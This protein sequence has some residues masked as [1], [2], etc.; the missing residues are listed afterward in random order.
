MVD[1]LG[2]LLSSQVKKGGFSTVFFHNSLENWPYFNPL[3][4]SPGMDWPRTEKLHVAALGE[5]ISETG[6]L[7]VSKTG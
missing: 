3:R 7:C 4:P 5:E 1:L 6:N 2:E